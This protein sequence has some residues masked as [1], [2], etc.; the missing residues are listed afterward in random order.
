METLIFLAIILL[1]LTPL[2]LAIFWVQRR[3]LKGKKIKGVKK[4]GRDCG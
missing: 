4:Q 2:F 3:A 1:S